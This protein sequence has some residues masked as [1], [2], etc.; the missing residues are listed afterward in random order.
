MSARLHSQPH[1][2]QSCLCQ[3]WCFIQ[4]T[5][6]RGDRVGRKGDAEHSGMEEEWDPLFQGQ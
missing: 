3:V 6:N 4:F 2:L 5:S 1:F